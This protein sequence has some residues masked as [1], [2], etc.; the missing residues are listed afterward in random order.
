MLGDT[1][2]ML[3][4]VPDPNDGADISDDYDDEEGKRSSL[5]RAVM[6]AASLFGKRRERRR[7]K[8]TE[9]ETRTKSGDNPDDLEQQKLCPK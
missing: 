8:E 4:G 9:T 7:R 2:T 5:F 3:D 1:S 6:N